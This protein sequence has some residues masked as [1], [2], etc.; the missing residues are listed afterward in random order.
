MEIR[1][2]L[3]CRNRQNLGV[4]PNCHIQ[5]GIGAVMKTCASSRKHDGDPIWLTGIGAINDMT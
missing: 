5:T 1:F 3:P 4:M 2:A